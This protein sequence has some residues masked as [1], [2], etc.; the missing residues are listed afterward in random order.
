MALRLPNESLR[1]A[2]NNLESVRDGDAVLMSCGSHPNVA[3]PE[4]RIA[5]LL[6][7][8]D[9]QEV[10]DWRF[11]VANTQLGFQQGSSGLEAARK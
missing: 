9:H 7:M 2:P 10:E 5:F 11:G 8:A 4:H 6:A 1:A 3:L